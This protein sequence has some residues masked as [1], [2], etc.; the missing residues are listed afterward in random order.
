MSASQLREQLHSSAAI[1]EASALQHAGGSS[2]PTLRRN[3]AHMTMAEGQGAWQSTAVPVRRKQ[4]VVDYTPYVSTVTCTCGRPCR[5]HKCVHWQCVRHKLHKRVHHCVAHNCTWL[6]RRPL[7]CS[8]HITLLQL[9]GAHLTARQQAQHQPTCCSSSGHT[10]IAKT[11]D[12]KFIIE[13]TTDAPNTQPQT[14]AGD[15]PSQ[16]APVSQAQPM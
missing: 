2:Q 3:A 8:P 6:L 16:Q 7:P 14:N 12:H 5:L 4:P 1:V 13:N 15:V 9:T 11:K 10:K